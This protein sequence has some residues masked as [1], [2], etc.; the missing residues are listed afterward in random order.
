MAAAQTAEGMSPGLLKV[1]ERAKRDPQVRFTSVA[2]LLDEQALKR[3]YDRLRK[4]AAVGMDGITKEQYGQELERHVSDLHERMRTMRYRHQPIR[5]VHIPKEKGKTRPLGISCVEDKVVQGALSEVL[6][7]LYEPVFFDG[8]FGFRRGR[9]AHDALRALDRVLQ[10]EVGWILEADIASFFDS[11]DRTMLMEMLRER[12]VDQPFLRLIGKCLHV[13]ILDG[14]EYTA[15][16]VGTVQGSVLSPMLGNIYLHHVLDVWFERDV[17]PRLQGQAHL[18]RY[19]DDFVIAFEKE[20]DA[21]RVMAVLPQRFG[22]F[23][24][25][26]HPDKTRVV[27]MGRPPSD[28]PK[29][30]GPATLDFLGFTLYWRRSRA[31]RW[32]PSFKTRRARLQRALQAVADECRRHR[33][34]PVKEQHAGLKRRLVGHFNYFGVNGNIRSLRKLVHGAERLWRKWLRRRSQRTRLT[35]ERFKATVLRAFPLPKPT[36]R[37]Q[38]WASS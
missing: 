3:A 4:D 32:V 5:R 16:D 13:G 22:R 9:S 26:L 6:E 33:H 19:A 36:I 31:G 30:K 29:G 27:P 15:P 35:W 24:L 12:V 8:S 18:I 7:A 10:G 14:E 28:H 1:M 21:K 17:R 20:E 37:V 25:T 34:K 11:I 2:H 38:I 23:G